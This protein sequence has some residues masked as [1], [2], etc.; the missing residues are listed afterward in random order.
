[1]ATLNDI[2][3][4]QASIVTSL[5]RSNP[6]LSFPDAVTHA[7]SVGKDHIASLINTLLLVYIGAALSQFLTFI[8]NWYDLSNPLLSVEIVRIVVPSIGI[9]IAVP[10]ATLIAAPLVTRPRLRPIPAVALGK[11]AL[12]G[13]RERHRRR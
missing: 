5:V 8:E 11:A 6:R 1:L 12:P 9:V 3:I 4:S 7:M 13:Q 10:M 2:T